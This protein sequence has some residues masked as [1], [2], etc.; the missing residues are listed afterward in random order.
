[1]IQLNNGRNIFLI[2]ILSMTK[3]N[4]NNC[5]KLVKKLLR[6]TMAN[7]SILKIFHDCRQ[8]SLALHRFMD[9]CVINVFDTSACETLI[10]QL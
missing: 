10:I 6:N 1:M 5:M 9:T 3:L 7:S 4:D 8:D 2:D